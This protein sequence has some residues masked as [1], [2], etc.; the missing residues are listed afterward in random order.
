MIGRREFLAGSLLAAS[1]LACGATTSTPTPTPRRTLR[2]VAAPRLR[3]TEAIVDQLVTAWRETTPV[4]GL[5]VA[6]LCDGEVAFARGHGKADLEADRDADADTIY[7][8]GSLTKPYTALTALRA[9]ADGHIDLEAPLRRYLPELRTGG[10]AADAITPRLLLCHRSGL[11]SDWHR[12]SMGAGPPWTELVREIADEPL[13][14]APDQW[15][16]YS[17]VGYTLLAHALE[18]ATGRPFAELLAA[19]V[20][21]E[22]GAAAPG[23][24][25]PDDLAAYYQNQRTIEPTLR[26]A[27]A[28]GLHASVL[29]MLPLLRWLLARGPLAAAMFDPQPAGPLDLDE[30]WGLGLS[31]RHSGLDHAGRVGC[32]LGRSYCHRSAMF[33]LPDHGLAVVALANAREGSGI[34]QLAVT[35]MQTALRERHGVAMPPSRGDALPPASLD[36]AALRA[37]AGRHATDSDILELEVDDGALVARAEA[38]AAWLRPAAGGE[39]SSSADPDARLRLRPVAGHH[40]LTARVRAVESRVGVRCPAEHVPEDWWRRLG[41]YRV[42]APADEVLAF[43]EVELERQGDALCLRVRSPLKEMPTLSRHAL[44]LVDQRQARIFGVGRGKGQQLTAEDDAPDGP[45]LRWAGYRLLR[46]R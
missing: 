8:I 28:A 3:E 17:N 23:L 30:R 10:P 9:A 39:F 26:L 21:A 45:Q 46:V 34:E 11:P 37:H 6:V 22:L 41:G 44:T 43:H 27:P 25:A 4:T 24:T 7:A 13:S 12:G 18:R 14:A 16:A 42:A 5:S 15:H 20:A 33:V 36:L 29:T 32:H 38:S 19:S 35:A 1:A 40:L 31:L 2:R